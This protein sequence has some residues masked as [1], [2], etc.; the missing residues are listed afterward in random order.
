M[1]K[2]NL[3]VSCIAVGSVV[4]L[5]GCQTLGGGAK[6]DEELAAAKAE[7]AAVQAEADAA[8]AEA[9]AET[10][11][12]QAEAETLTMA[13]KSVPGSVL[14]Q[15][16]TLLFAA[17]GQSVAMAE[18]GALGVA[19]ARVAAETIAKVNL[20][21]I[22]KGALISSSVRVGDME[23]ES[24]TVTATVSGWLGGVV[25]ETSSTA[26]DQ[27]RLPDAEATDET[28]TCKASLEISEKAWANLQDYVE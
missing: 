22:L 13:A 19:K 14:T 18:D 10:A 11:A 26:E 8:I 15:N 9:K 28:V 27:S 21:E 16:G 23:F 12:A 5:S 4:V 17:Q 24:Q 6:A 3:V 2:L 7:T 20:L 25:L 1:N